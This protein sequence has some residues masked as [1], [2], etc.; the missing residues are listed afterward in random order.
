MVMI[1][2]AHFTP[3]VTW[4]LMV[5]IIL[6]LG[7]PMYLRYHSGRWREMRVVGV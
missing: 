1:H 5:L 2:Y 3:R 4:L 6:A 7:V